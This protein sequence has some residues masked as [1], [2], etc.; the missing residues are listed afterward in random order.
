M[1]FEHREENARKHYI[2]IPIWLQ[3][4]TDGR[5]FVRFY[6]GLRSTV[7]NGVRALSR[8]HEKTLESN[9]D[10]VEL[11]VWYVFLTC[12]INKKPTVKHDIF[13]CSKM[14]VFYHSKTRAFWSSQNRK[15]L[16]LTF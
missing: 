1:A 4:G 12:F 8:K 2:F 13:D 15:V 10:S 7:N 16:P 3:I 5:V 6:V 11:F 9:H 14:Q